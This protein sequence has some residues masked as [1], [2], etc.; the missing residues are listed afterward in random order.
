MWRN[1]KDPQG[2]IRDQKHLPE[3]QRTCKRKQQL[4]ALNIKQI[5][6]SDLQYS[7]RTYI[8]YLVITYNEEE[9]EKG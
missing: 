8:Q 4:C 9:P 7:T 5:N 6:N 3:L 2:K 1:I